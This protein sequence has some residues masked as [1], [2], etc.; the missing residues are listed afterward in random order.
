MPSVIEM[1]TYKT[2]A[3]R[4]QYFMDILL[5][6]LFPIQRQIGMKVLGPFPS[7]EDADT[8]FWMRGFPDA[9]ARDRMRDEFYEGAIWKDDLQDMLLPILEKY[10]VVLV[11]DPGHLLDAPFWR[12]FAKGRSAWRQ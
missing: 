7:V 2:K 8:F 3:G 6:R 1:R 5:E 12:S 4:R 9:T 11:E 10:D